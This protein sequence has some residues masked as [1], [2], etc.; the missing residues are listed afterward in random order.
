MERIASADDGL[1]ADVPVERRKFSAFGFC[2]SKKIDIGQ[3]ATSPGLPEIENIR[4]RETYVIRPE[5]VVSL[6]L[7]F[8][9]QCHDVLWFTRPVGIFR[10]RHDPRDAVFGYRTARPSIFAAGMEPDGSAMVEIVVLVEQRDEDV[11]V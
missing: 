8:V 3:V 2:Q 9:Q 10:M 11:N 4:V 1:R 6:G 5:D 7:Q